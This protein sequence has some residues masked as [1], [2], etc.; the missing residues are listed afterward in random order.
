M[1]SYLLGGELRGVALGNVLLG[2]VLLGN[3]RVAPE[4]PVSRLLFS[5]FTSSKLCL[6]NL[7]T[8]SVE[9]FSKKMIYI[10]LLHSYIPDPEIFCSPAIPELFVLT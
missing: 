7:Q 2:N 9:R 1:Y 6:K 5:A 4:M 10:L 3:V 8:C